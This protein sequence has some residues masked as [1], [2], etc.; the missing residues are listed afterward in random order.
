M[1]DSGFF[2]PDEFSDGFDT[3]TGK[4]GRTLVANS[5]QFWTIQN[6]DTATGRHP[7]VRATAKAFRMS[8]ADVREAVT[9]H[10]WMFITGPDDDPTQQFIEHEGE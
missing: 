6:Y 5:I 10:Y 1:S 9:C 2:A 7:S 4:P 3:D 8:D